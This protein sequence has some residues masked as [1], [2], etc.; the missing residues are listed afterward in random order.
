MALMEPVQAGVFEDLA[1]LI[2]QMVA[3][4]NRDQFPALTNPTWVGATEVEYLAEDDLILGVYLN[5]V[6]KA[7][8]ENLG[9]WHEVINDEIGGQY[10]SVTFCPLTG[11]GLNYNA[12]N[13]D[14]GQIELG[15]S[16]LLLNSNLVVYDRGDGTTLFPQ[17]LF[18]GVNGARTGERLELLPVVETTWALW[19][20]FYP[21]TLVPQGGTGL[22]GYSASIQ[23]N[24]PPRL[25]SNDPYADYRGDHSSIPFPPA[26]GFID[27]T[28]PAKATVLGICYGDQRKAYVFGAMGRQV[29][30]NDFLDDLFMVI[31]YDAESK[32][33]IPYKGEID[34]Q[35]MAFY[36][37]DP[38]GEFPVEFKDVET[39][40]RWNMLG[41]AVEGP[42]RGR[43]LEQVSA[44]NAMWFAWAAFWP[45]T[46]VW[47]G[48][49]VLDEIDTAVADDAAPTLPS[50]FTLGQN[51]PNPFNAQTQ[52]EYR[53]AQGGQIHLAVYDLIGQ[54]VRTLAAG[55]K[56]AGTYVAQW[57]GR[58]GDGNEVGS[59]IYVYRLEASDSQLH[60]VRRMVLVR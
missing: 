27:P 37:V 60:L 9:W 11:T 10:V 59:G 36:Q 41:R 34:G 5:G 54:R 55:H 47:D 31:V 16:G 44:Y 40:S 35:A 6:A 14:G 51:F 18:T 46:Q 17:M 1:G 32:T 23:S 24:Y 58:D 26:S 20:K 56:A 49:G 19:K 42:L 22:D 50:Q 57:D 25:Y 28:F 39:G 48:E 53:L 13:P 38:V 29:V 2:E 12:T 15:V 52:I 4:G 7:Y 33:A 45:Q 21:D 8:P 3:L 30:I 43:Q